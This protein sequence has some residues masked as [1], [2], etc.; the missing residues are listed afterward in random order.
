MDMRLISNS[1]ETGLYYIFNRYATIIA[2]HM[3]LEG[4]LPVFTPYRNSQALRSI[5]QPSRITSCGEHLHAKSGLMT[6]E[7]KVLRA[8][9]TL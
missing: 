6:I 5:A 9:L 4:H 2:S 1:D 3:K 7:Q 8:K